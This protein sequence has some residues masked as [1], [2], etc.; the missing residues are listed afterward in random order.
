MAEIH[1]ETELIPYLRG[2]LSADERARVGAHL[3]GCA[4]C[5]ASAEASSAILTSLARVVDE[6]RDPDWTAYRAELTRKLRARQVGNA[7]LRGRWR[8][9]RAD[10][11]LPV[12]GWPSM[13]LGTAAVAV[14]A[15]ALVFHRGAGMP[16]VPGVDQLEL[17]QELGSADVGL[18]ANYHVVEH[19]DLLENYDVIEHLDELGP[20]NSPNNATP[21]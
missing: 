4:Q 19:L 20:G 14:L 5:R 3:E 11:R 6:V 21:S 2:E 12:F 10:L 17:Q 13:A 9:R 18:L 16:P 1:P 7:S 15:I 8:S